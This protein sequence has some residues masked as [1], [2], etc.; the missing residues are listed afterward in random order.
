MFKKVKLGTKIVGG[1]IFLIFLSGMVSFIG[2]TGMRQIMERVEKADSTNQMILMILQARRH[3]KNFILRNEAKYVD[4]VR[5]EVGDLKRLALETKGKFRDPVNRSQMDKVLAATDQYEKAF[6]RV[7]ELAG[8]NSGQRVDQVSEFPEIDKVLI[9][10]ARTVEKECTEARLN[11]KQKMENQMQWSTTLLVAGASAALI[12][13]LVAAFLITRSI[14]RPVQRVIQGLVEGA[15]QVTAAA[16]EVS[17]ASQSLAEGASEQA[18]G[19]EQTSSS[20]EEMSSMTRQNADHARQA[21]SMMGEVQQIVQKV[22]THMDQM[23]QAITEITRTSEETEKIIKTID[24]IAFQTNLLA[25]NAAVEAARAGEAGAGFAVVADEV[26]NLAMRAAEAAKNTSGL[27]ENT[28]SAI[29]RGNELTR[30]TRSAFQEN[31][32]VAGNISRLIDEIA[33]ASQEQA[34]GITE[35]SQAVSQMDRIVQQNAAAAEES[36]SASEELNAQSEQMRDLVQELQALVEGVGRE[37]GSVAAGSRPE[38]DPRRLL[39]NAG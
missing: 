39:E 30:E 10:T 37:N 32:T 17:S 7:V 8:K 9:Q 29:R 31:T 36:A 28:I 19:L 23:G 25:L 12:I 5:K 15:T 3:E 14:T 21:K 22:N 26:R 16:A 38:T 1:F 34:Q 35:V 27:I 11:Q 13:G 2:W 24:E 20:M 33:A 6:G 18:A 4:N